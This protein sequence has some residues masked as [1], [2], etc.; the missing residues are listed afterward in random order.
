[1]TRDTLLSVRCKVTFC[2]YFS[3]NIISWTKRFSSTFRLISDKTG[4][5]VV[6]VDH[7]D[8]KNACKLLA[9]A[10]E[11][12]DN[13]I[14]DWFP[15]LDS[16]NIHGEKPV[17]RIGLCPEC[18]METMEGESARHNAVEQASIGNE[19]PVN[20]NGSEAA[21]I[22]N[23]NN[24]N[25]ISGMR[26]NSVIVKGKVARENKKGLA[27]SMKT[28]NEIVKDKDKK[29]TTGGI[30]G[31]TGS[32]ESMSEEAKESSNKV[33]SSEY[34]NNST[35]AET[36]DVAKDEVN[37]NREESEVLQEERAAIESIKG[38]E[39]EEAMKKI[40]ADEHICCITHGEIE[41]SKIFPDLVCP[42]YF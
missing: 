42:Y 33:G 15:A 24:I 13:L 11:H 14:T 4:F 40:D 20:G 27:K 2:H 19:V 17:R 16:Q 25:R 12:F 8:S 41:Y 34:Q 18:L 23:G 38:F 9:L 36:E 37:Q 5:K 29:D 31:S 30:Q 7:N 22:S 32:A 39:F 1:M 26:S 28:R 21:P 3:W 6:G 10:T 35:R